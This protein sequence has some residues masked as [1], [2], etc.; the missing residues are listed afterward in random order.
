MLNQY[1]KTALSKYPYNGDLQPKNIFTF[2]KNEQQKLNDEIE[3]K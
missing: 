3:S 2:Q 1:V